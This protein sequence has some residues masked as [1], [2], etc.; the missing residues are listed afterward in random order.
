[1]EPSFSPETTQT[2]RGYSELEATG[3]E[4]GSD[5]A[6]V[7]CSLQADRVRRTAEAAR[8]LKGSLVNF[9]ISSMIVRRCEVKTEHVAAPKNARVSLR[10]GQKASPKRDS[11]HFRWQVV[12]DAKQA[13]N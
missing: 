10:K 13:W 1:M 8:L 6:E 7:L 3:F 2:S 12:T 4:G 5:S 11:S 9:I